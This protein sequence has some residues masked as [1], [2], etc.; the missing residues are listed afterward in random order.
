MCDPVRA[1]TA[2]LVASSGAQAYASLRQGQ[3]Q[4]RA[5]D[6]NAA[7]ARM[8]AGQA[9]ADAAF[10]E[11]RFRDQTDSVLLDQAATFGKGGVRLDQGTALELAGRTAYEIET[12]ALLIRQRGDR[13]ATA[14]LNDATLQT[15]AAKAARDQGRMGAAVALLNGAMQ[16]KGLTNNTGKGGAAGKGG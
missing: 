6:Y 2:L 13:E 14:Y 8:N 1:G 15:R 16:W 5:Y 4:G 10:E 9:R 3:A 12:D 7:V 11:G